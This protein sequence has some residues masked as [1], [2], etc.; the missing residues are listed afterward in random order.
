MD[1]LRRG[2][3]LTAQWFRDERNLAMYKSDIYNL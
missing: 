1:G 2:L 3:V